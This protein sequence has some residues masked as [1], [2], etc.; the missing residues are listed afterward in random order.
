LGRAKGEEGGA[1]PL[2]L[3]VAVDSAPAFEPAGL[4]KE[5]HF[6]AA[7]RLL[8]IGLGSE[9]A[10]ELREIDLAPYRSSPEGAEPIFLVAA[11]L[12]LS[13]DHR[14]AHAILKADGRSVLRSSPTGDRL[15]LWRIAYPEAFRGDVLRYS[16]PAG[17]P[18]DLLQALMREESALDPAVISPAG[19]IGLTQLMPS[20][21]AAMARRLGIGAISATSLMDPVVNIRIG[22]AYLG[23]LLTR[24]GG[25]PALALAAYNAGSGAVGR[26][27]EARGSLELDE[28]V[29]EIP[30]DETRGYVKRVL[31]TFAAYRLLSVQKEAAPLDLLPRALRRAAHSEAISPP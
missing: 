1:L 27:L 22:A 21:A 24:Y 8:R 10:E 31:R 11:L 25:Q 28:F 9:A 7:V 2:P 19:A 26:W 16:K 29:E 12:D 14:S 18:P 6:R 13:G 15:R 5:P 20:T 3:G 17:V 30:I 4:R 23:E